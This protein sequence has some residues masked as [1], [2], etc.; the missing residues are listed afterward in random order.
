MLKY[1]K[2]NINHLGESSVSI[3][4]GD[5]RRGNAKESVSMGKI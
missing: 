2:S 5:R 1:G 3:R 4:K